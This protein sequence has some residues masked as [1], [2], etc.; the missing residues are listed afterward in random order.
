[1][2]MNASNA[3]E[4]AGPKLRTVDFCKLNSYIP[5]TR[6]NSNINKYKLVIGGKIL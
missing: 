5:N 3:I 6:Y 2:R 4:R 1:M